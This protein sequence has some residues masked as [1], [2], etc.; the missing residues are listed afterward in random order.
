[1]RDLVFAERIRVAVSGG[2]D[3][4]ALLRVCGIVR[5]AGH[6]RLRGHFNQLRKASDS[7]GGKLARSKGEIFCRVR[8]V[9]A[10]PS[11][12]GRIWMRRGEPLCFFGNW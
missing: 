6:R 3:S 10:K 1:V 8:N 4:V 2:A 9:G 5:I 11:A 12:S 7:D